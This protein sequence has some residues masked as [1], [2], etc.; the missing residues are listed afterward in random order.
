MKRHYHKWRI[1]Y[2][3]L[4]FGLR[5]LSFKP[6]GMNFSFKGAGFWCFDLQVCFRVPLFS[7]AVL[8]S[9]N[10]LRLGRDFADAAPEPKPG[11]CRPVV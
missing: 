10:L 2:Y 1:R 8:Q 9:A 4:G 6:Q 7:A 11:C 3:T 5:P